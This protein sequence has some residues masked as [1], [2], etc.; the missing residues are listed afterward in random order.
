MDTFLQKYLDQG[1]LSKLPDSAIANL[2][3]LEKKL[4]N[5]LPGNSTFQNVMGEYGP[6]INDLISRIS[7]HLNNWKF[8]LNGVWDTLKFV[9]D[10]A[11][12]VYQ[13]VEAVQVK[14]V[15]NGTAPEVA[16]QKK[17]DFGVDM[18]YFIWATIGPL[19]GRLDWLPFKATLEKWL[20]RK[21]AL[22]GIQHAM[23]FFNANPKVTT[24]SNA[25]LSNAKMTIM[26]STL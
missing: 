10:I 25:K 12:E 20:V 7:D 5:Q 15:P 4:D 8:S 3:N 17:T 13:I 11:K 2:T 24:L 16:L 26:K 21:L 19:K 18:V 23:S 14:I 22:I 6:E 9:I 1:T